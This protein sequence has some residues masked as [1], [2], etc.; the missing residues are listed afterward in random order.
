[1]E[2]LLTCMH[3]AIPNGSLWWDLF[4]SHMAQ[5]WELP[6]ST[7]YRRGESYLIS[8]RSRLHYVNGLCVWLPLIEV[9]IL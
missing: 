7:P 4:Q 9:S 2:M 8:I 1:M 5:C 3:R 6:V